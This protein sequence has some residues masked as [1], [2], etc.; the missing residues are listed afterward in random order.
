MRVLRRSSW[1][2]TLLELMIAVGLAAVV[3]S[4]V[5]LTTVQ[6]SRTVRTAEE[7]G[8]LKRSIIMAAEQMRWQIRCLYYDKKAAA[9]AVK[10]A[11][12]N[13]PGTL[14]NVGLYGQRGHEQDAGV[15]LFRTTAVPKRGGVFTNGTVEVGY[16]IL[17]DKDGSRYLAYRQYPWVD[18]LGLHTEAQDP[19]AEWTVL[20]KE[21]TGLSVEY[22]KDGELWMQEWTMEEVP[23]FVRFTLHLAKGGSLE[24]D[25]APAQVSPRW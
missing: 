17:K 22:S 7:K 24:V 16:C 19:N 12:N 21:I 25:A 11:S 13:L 5:S 1:G 18:R 2:F 23:L 4:L 9:H 10:A 20:S 8:Q 3:Y 6:L 14:G 15:L